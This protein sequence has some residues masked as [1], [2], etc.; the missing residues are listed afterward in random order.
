MQPKNRDL[1][2]TNTLTRPLNPQRPYTLA[3]P[4]LNSYNLLRPRQPLQPHGNLHRPLPLRPT[5]HSPSHNPQAMRM[6]L[7]RTFAPQTGCADFR[8]VYL[9]DVDEESVAGEAADVMRAR[10]VPEDA[11][12]GS[13]KESGKY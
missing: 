8:G 3:Q 4:I 12:E 10:A 13:L 9:I 2:P 1:A 6:I 7:N 11:C 5:L